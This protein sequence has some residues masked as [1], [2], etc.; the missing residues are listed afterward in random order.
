LYDVKFISNID[1]A[2]TGGEGEKRAGASAYSAT[3]AQQFTI[4][5][6]LLIVNSQFTDSR[7]LPHAKKQ[8]FSVSLKVLTAALTLI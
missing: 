2:S 6:L 1:L 3:R 4:Y 8:N 7:K 5:Y